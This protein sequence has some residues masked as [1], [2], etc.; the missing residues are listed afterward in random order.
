M[1]RVLF[2]RPQK[3]HLWGMRREQ[4]LAKSSRSALVS[5]E[6]GFLTRTHFKTITKQ[7]K[8]NRDLKKTIVVWTRVM[9]WRVRT[10]KPRE[11]RM[12]KG[13][14]AKVRDWV[15]PVRKGQVIL[16]F[17]KIKAKRGRRIL[18]QLQYR[19]PIHTAIQDQQLLDRSFLRIPKFQHHRWV[20]ANLWKLF[21]RKRRES[22]V[23][24]KLS[25]KL[26]RLRGGIWLAKTPKLLMNLNKFKLQFKQYKETNHDFYRKHNSYSG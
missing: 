23:N 16:E 25:E 13:K 5:R 11:V 22:F 10:R 7:I 1:K 4:K 15:A 26:K 18:K 3:G 12:G 24:R 6:C 17:G 2:A 19:L 20:A 9:P 8:L 21:V 14:G